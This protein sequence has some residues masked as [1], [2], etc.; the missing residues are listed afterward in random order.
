M[1]V[2]SKTFSFFSR[3]K[4]ADHAQSDVL[5]QFIKIS[6]PQTLLYETV[7]FSIN[8]ILSVVALLFNYYLFSQMAC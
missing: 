8:F 5:S 1:I 3:L 2:K 7:L 4:K 6:Q